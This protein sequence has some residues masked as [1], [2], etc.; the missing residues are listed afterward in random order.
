VDEVDSN[1]RFRFGLILFQCLYDADK[2]PEAFK[3]FES[4]F[5]R[6]KAKKVDFL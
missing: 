6:C 5:E 2:K 1:W 4:L 3:Y